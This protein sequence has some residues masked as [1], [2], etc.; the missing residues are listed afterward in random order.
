ME[1]RRGEQCPGVSGGNGEGEGD[2]RSRQ[3]KKG[4]KLW[5]QKTRKRGRNYAPHL[6]QDWVW[7]Q[8]YPL[9]H[10]E[11]VGQRGETLSQ[12]LIC[13]HCSFNGDLH[14]ISSHHVASTKNNKR[15][16]EGLTAR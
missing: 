16:R 3:V 11:R 15:Q 13:A 1:E 4:R 9:I 2:G 5:E 10:G 12:G 8:V 6:L 7:L 14:S